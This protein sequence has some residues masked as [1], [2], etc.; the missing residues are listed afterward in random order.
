MGSVS[1]KVNNGMAAMLRTACHRGLWLPRSQSCSAVQS[2]SNSKT[3]EVPTR[4]TAATHATK[5]L[6]G[7]VLGQVPAPSCSAKLAGQP[8][9]AL[10]LTTF[11]SNLQSQGLRQHSRAGV[12][13]EIPAASS[14]DV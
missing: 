8:A 7:E 2:Q 3:F 5:A 14:W 6:Q 13:V 11:L 12:L 4:V 9:V 10:L 1:S